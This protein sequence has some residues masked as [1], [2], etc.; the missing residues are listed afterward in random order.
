PRYLDRR[1]IRY[2][3]Y[4]GRT[5]A[6][7]DQCHFTDKPAGADQAQ[8]LRLSGVRQHP[9]NLKLAALDQPCS[10][11][12]F[13]LA[14]QH[15]SSGEILTFQIGLLQVA[16]WIAVIQPKSQPSNRHPA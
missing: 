6:R 9:H 10:V 11:A 14:D 3:A 1:D 7:V 12:M 4:M 5:R 13:V 2:A 16:A 15:G 8:S